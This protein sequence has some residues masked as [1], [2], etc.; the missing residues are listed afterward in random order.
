MRSRLWVS[1]GFLCERLG[2]V[3]FWF[4]LSVEHE[5]LTWRV[6]RARA[7]GLPL[8]GRMFSAVQAREGEVAGRYTFDVSA[9]LPVAG[10]LI[11]YRGW[12]HVDR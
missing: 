5:G 3:T 7:L 10:M 9:A 1:D 4:R 11:R 8:P 2:L 12:L 6:A